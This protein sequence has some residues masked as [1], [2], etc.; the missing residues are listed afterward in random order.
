[1]DRI[2][3]YKRSS[4]PVWIKNVWSLI[5]K[6]LVWQLVLV[7]SFLIFGLPQVVRGEPPVQYWANPAPSGT[8]HSNFWS[9][10]SDGS[11]PSS[12]AAFNSAIFSATNAGATGN[13][14]VTLDSAATVQ[15][16]TYKG[17]HSGSTLTIAAG[18]GAMTMFLSQ[19]MVAIDAGTTMI[20]APAITETTPGSRLILTGGTLVLQGA[21]TYSGGTI[22]GERAT[23]VA[24]SNHALGTGTVKL[25]AGTLI[26][27]A[28]V[29]L[30][31]K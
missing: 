11:S 14:T 22:I 16:L 30:A 3:F 4:K 9:F 21:N 26:I 24:D 23:L 6:R 17:G 8:W 10:D 7:S 29:T 31:M 18:A 20:L 25:S 15:N 1:M 2:S 5:R 19:M 28:G 27:P 13:F 12:W